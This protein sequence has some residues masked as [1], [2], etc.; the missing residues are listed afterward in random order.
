MGSKSL[1]LCVQRNRTASK[2][3]KQVKLR[4]AHLPMRIVA[5]FLRNDEEELSIEDVK[6]KFSVNYTTAQRALCRLSDNGWLIRREAGKNSLYSINR[7][8]LDKVNR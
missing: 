8:M 3:I 4:T 2:G 6:S 1:P 5:F 7:D